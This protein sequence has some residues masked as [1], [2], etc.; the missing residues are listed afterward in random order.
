MHWELK[1]KESI[2]WCQCE[3]SLAI[4]PTSCCGKATDVW[5]RLRGHKFIW[6]GE[7]EKRV[8]RNLAY[9]HAFHLVRFLMWVYKKKKKSSLW[10]FPP[11]MS[12]KSNWRAWHQWRG[13]HSVWQCLPFIYLLCAMRALTPSSLL[14]S[15][16]LTNP[17]SPLSLSPSPLRTLSLSHLSRPHPFPCISLALSLSLSPTL[18]LC[19]PVTSIAPW[20]ILVKTIIHTEKKHIQADSSALEKKISHFNYLSISFLNSHLLS[21]WICILRAQD[22][23]NTPPPMWIQ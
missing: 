20:V 11:L 3:R 2:W 4:F 14:P 22:R 13:T 9:M 5:R 18:P 1:H 17:S 19:I 10:V 7:K 16:W 21:V 8:E 15:L 6:G 23:A 12:L